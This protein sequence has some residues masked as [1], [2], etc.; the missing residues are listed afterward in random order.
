MAI[1]RALHL[2]E[3][4]ERLVS[5]VDLFISHSCSNHFNANW[6]NCYDLGV[7]QKVKLV[8]IKRKFLINRVKEEK[9]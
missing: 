3:L 1:V 5:S 7:I 2:L 4:Y 9:D 8:K 6:L